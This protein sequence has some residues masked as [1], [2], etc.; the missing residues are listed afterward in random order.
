MKYKMLLLF[1][2]ISISIFS[3]SV[4]DTPDVRHWLD[5]MFKHID[6]TKVPHGI[7]RDYAFELADL[8]IYNGKELNSINY[9]DRIAFENLLRT[10][11]SGSLGANLFD[12]KEILANQYALGG[13]GKGVVGVV[14]YQYSYI[15][16]DA[17]TSNLIRYENGQVLDNVINNIWQNPYASNYTLG[18]SP[19]DSI[20]LGSV[21]H[22]SFPVNLWLSNITPSSIE[23]DA[24]D[25][26]GYVSVSVGGNLSVSYGSSGVK[27]LKIRIKL[28]D[29][30][31][32]QSHSLTKVLTDE[33]LTRSLKV[34]VS[35]DRQEDIQSAKSYNG[36]ITHGKLC[37]LY[38]TKSQAKI[39]RPLIVVEGFDPL[40][41]IPQDQEPYQGDR[42]YG[43][44]HLGSFIDEL[45]SKNSNIYNRLREEYDIIYVDLL[46]SKQYI[47]ANAKLLETVIETINKEKEKNGSKE[48]NVILAQS[49]GGLIAKYALRVMENE[50]RI[51]D[52]SLLICHDTPHQG[53]HI[54]LGVLYGAH[55]MLDFYY[56]KSI[57]GKAANLGSV[58]SQIS[59]VLYCNAA[60]QMLINYV[61][62]KGNLDNSI[63]NAWQSELSQM[64]YPQ[65][66]NG[67]KMRMVS[68][69]N[70]QTSVVKT[71]TPY[72]YAD[73]N[74]S[75]TKLTELLSEIYFFRPLSGIALGIVAQDWQTFVL[76]ILP[77]SNTISAHVEIS[78][79]YNTSQICNIYLRYV[80]KFL[81]TAKVQ[82]TIYSYKKNWPSSM[83]NYDLM[84]GSY[85]AYSGMSDLTIG[86]G[87]VPTLA[88]LFARYKLD[89][90]AVEKTMFIPTVSSL[91]IGEGKVTLTQS[92]YEKEY[93]M[94]LPPEAPKHTP[95]D[96][97]YI[98]NGSTRHISFNHDMLTWIIEQMSVLIDGPEIGVTGSKYSIRNN[99]DNYSVIWNSSDESIAIIDNSGV[100]NVRR[101]GFVVLTATCV[102]GNMKNRF[103]K[104]IMAGFPPFTLEWSINSDYRISA[105]CIEPMAQKFLRY[106][107]YEWAQKERNS[108][109]GA[110]SW[111][112]STDS[113]Y[114]IAPSTQSSK[115]TIYMRPVNENGS[116][117][118]PVFISL[119]TT[120]P[121]QLSPS[122]SMVILSP[123]RGVS[124]AYI[125]FSP[126][127][128]YAAKND[129][130]SE[131]LA[132]SHVQ[133]FPLHT[134][135]KSHIIRF[136]NPQIG[137]K[138]YIKDLYDLERLKQWYHS[139]NQINGSSG[140]TTITIRIAL[141]N[142]FNNMVLTTPVFIRFLKSRL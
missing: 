108:S 77:G 32:L 1:C 139:E 82:R 3:Q 101:H 119:D 138:I 113:V 142:K 38:S 86:L 116:K 52:T 104:Y 118:E 2:F 80:K 37:Y 51:H 122:N 41:F 107:S 12:V 44:T 117:G 42:N 18:F 61:D 43:T 95:F 105:K 46:D 20:L 50:G 72:L 112:K 9:V 54:P 39:T 22:Y 14:L 135:E 129:L 90:N 136:N 96:A 103:Y 28:Q 26:K 102:K 35:P 74:I 10:I 137:Q 71:N 15:R 33:V 23:F 111:T 48:K 55:A 97:F 36:I 140:R 5:T 21:I 62:P 29:G 11:R 58:I 67:Y 115:R 94:D 87:K 19:Q 53:A 128:L 16:A 27:H 133:T 8:D 134:W 84:P 125:E 30:T 4:E 31:S 123:Y 121:Y 69:S 127:P 131:Q 120:T 75:L 40:E 56:N 57:I 49:M 6:K 83:I 76:G 17:L 110:L 59:P 65:G 99:T 126:N 132:I 63:H 78:P 79:G 98:T 73:G 64:G 47:Q 92:D 109:T 91:D 13:K 124:D 24:D 70:G 106:M 81:W 60:K 66:D 25:G 89:V 141:M 100:L 68:I 85:Y 130:N 34:W 93:L 45:S 88:Q 114:K 7:L